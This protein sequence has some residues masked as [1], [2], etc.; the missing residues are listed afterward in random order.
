MCQ[1][2]PL[3]ARCTITASTASSTAKDELKIEAEAKF[4]YAKAFGVSGGGSIGVVD[5]NWATSH[6]VVIETRPASNIAISGTPGTK[7]MTADPNYAGWLVTVTEDPAVTGMTVSPI[8]ELFTGAKHSAMLDAT[9]E[10]VK[11]AIYASTTL[12]SN[13][14][15]PGSIVLAGQAA[16]P[17][18]TAAAAAIGSLR[19]WQVVLD[20]HDL[21]VALSNVYAGHG[22]APAKVS[23]DM[24]A[25]ITPYL[26]DARY[27]IILTT[28]VRTELAGGRNFVVTNDM[29]GPKRPGAAFSP[30]QM[31]YLDA[32]RAMGAADELAKATTLLGAPTPTYPGAWVGYAFIGVSGAGPV[33]RQCVEV[34]SFEPMGE[35]PS[36]DALN[37]LLEPEDDGQGG[38]T[39]TPIFES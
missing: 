1:P 5:Q 14:P 2:S 4:E 31:G 21:T 10:F 33:S 39:Y 38:V 11:T 23:G 34:C 6:E 9:Q 20:T 12:T 32:L 13:S 26:N 18:N 24:L 19:A 35:P 22:A 27:V 25:D 36:T 16:T 8:A 29:F 30:G 15:L 17:R 7:D 28:F 37:V 3:A